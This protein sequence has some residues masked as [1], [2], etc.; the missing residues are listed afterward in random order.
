MKNLF[1]F[2]FFVF[3]CNVFCIAQDSI[4]RH[5]NIQHN[6]YFEL[7]GNSIAFYNITYDCSF[8]IAEKHKIAVGF[9]GQYFPNISGFQNKMFGL[10]PQIN[11]LYGKRHHLELGTGY[12]IQLMPKEYELDYL[13]TI[14]VRVGYRFQKSEG[15]YFWKIGYVALFGEA[16]RGEMWR[17]FPFVPWSGVAWGYTFKNKK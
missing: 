16:I 1:A 11:Y 10:S 13:A 2:I 8:K 5:N 17:S 14:P 7:L 12:T 6:L 9:G 15:G 4:K 3:F